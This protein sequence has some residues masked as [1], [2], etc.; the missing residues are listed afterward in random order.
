MFALGVPREFTV[1]IFIGI[2]SAL[3]LGIGLALG[4]GG[5]DHMNDLVKKVR[6]EFRQ[7]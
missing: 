1:I 2:V 3:A 4:M 6:D 5:K 7:R